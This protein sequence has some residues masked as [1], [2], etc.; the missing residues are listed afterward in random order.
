[1]KRLVVLAA[2]VGLG[3]VGVAGNPAEAHPV[4]NVTGNWQ[5][6]VPVTL[7]SYQPSADNPTIGSYA[8]VGTTAWL[9]TWTGLTRYQIHGTANLVTGAGS[10]VIDETFT[11]GSA[12]GKTGTMRFLETYTIDSASQIRIVARLVSGTGDFSGSKADVVFLGI[13]YGA[14]TGNGTYSGTWSEPK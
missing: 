7:T 14:A 12:D 13:E 2:A 8:G 5:T 9:G 6:V 1:M 11:G 3:V 4:P 10:G